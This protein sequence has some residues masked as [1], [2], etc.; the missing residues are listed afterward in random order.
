MLLQLI[1]QICS[2]DMGGGV[3]LFNTLVRG[4]P[5]NPRQRNLA[6]R[7]SRH[8]SIMRCKIYCDILNRLGVAHESR[9]WRTDRRTDRQPPRTV[10][11][12]QPCTPWTNINL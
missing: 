5:L 2:F 6:S 12:L 3:P 4:E 7:N 1:G 8:R 10:G 9:V 11:Y